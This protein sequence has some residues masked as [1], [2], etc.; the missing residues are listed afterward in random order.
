MGRADNEG[1]GLRCADRE[2][3]MLFSGRPVNGV[4]TSFA[5][6]LKKAGVLQVRETCPFV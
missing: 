4:P 1:G 6:D 2:S 5:L 3:L